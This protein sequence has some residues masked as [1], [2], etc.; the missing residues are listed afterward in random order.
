MNR[1]RYK[2]PKVELEALPDGELC[3]YADV[4]KLEDKNRTLEALKLRLPLS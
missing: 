2:G 4:Q 3:F 1:Y